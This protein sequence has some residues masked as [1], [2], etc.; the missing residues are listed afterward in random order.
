VSAAQSRS[1]GADGP[2]R[3]RLDEALTAARA[4]LEESTRARQL[5]EHGSE[6]DAMPTTR[7]SEVPAGATQGAE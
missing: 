7:A 2:E 6:E 4:A 3:E 1:A 5:V